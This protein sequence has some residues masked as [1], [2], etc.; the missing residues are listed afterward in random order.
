MSV[1][2]VLRTSSLPLRRGVPTH[3]SSPRGST[4]L[5]T[6]SVVR[7]VVSVG[8]PVSQVYLLVGLPLF[9]EMSRTGVTPDPTSAYADLD[10]LQYPCVSIHSDVPRTP[11]R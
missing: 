7:V 10:T 11:N 1:A 9:T 3:L 8:R 4:G 5:E 6:P 2:H